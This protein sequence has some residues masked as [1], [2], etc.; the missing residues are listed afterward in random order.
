LDKGKMRRGNWT[1]MTEVGERRAE[2]VVDVSFPVQMQVRV[3]ESA[4]GGMRDGV[5]HLQN[6]PRSDRGCLVPSVVDLNWI[7]C[8]RDKVFSIPKK[9]NT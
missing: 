8:Y 5:A 1:L 6:P 9:K 4:L 3:R 7:L 2:K